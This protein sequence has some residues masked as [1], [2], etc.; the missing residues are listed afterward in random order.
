LRWYEGIGREPAKERWAFAFSAK[1]KWR[2]KVQSD[3]AKIVKT[4]R[5][6]KLV[7]FITNQYV[8]DKK[9]SEVEDKLREEYSID[10]RILDRGWIIK[11]VFE[12]NR[13]LLAIDSLRLTGFD[14]KQHRRTGPRDAKRQKELEALERQISDPNRYNGVEYQLAEDSLQA[15]LL[16]RHLELPRVEVEGRFQRAERIAEEVGNPQQMLRIKSIKLVGFPVGQP[17][18][19]KHCHF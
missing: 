4:N 3:V 9:R 7:Y 5:G 16:A 18:S 8:S 10:V 6:Y 11:S 2:A 13:I 14:E 15:S 17:I 12:N 1:E 19:E